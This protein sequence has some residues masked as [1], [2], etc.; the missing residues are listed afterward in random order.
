MCLVLDRRVLK[1]SAWGPEGQPGLRPFLS[2]SAPL[3][4]VFSGCSL[5]SLIYG[6][7]SEKTSP[8]D[9]SLEMEHKDK[10]SA[11]RGLGPEGSSLWAA[12]QPRAG[13]SEVA[14]RGFAAR[15]T[16]PGSVT[17]TKSSA[18]PALHLPVGKIELFTV[19]TSK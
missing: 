15:D 12:A 19:P 4:T 8:S 18:L 7:Q 14:L 13:R 1:L 6:E 2:F 5:T 3:L 9:I 10:V 11:R 17:W 16:Q